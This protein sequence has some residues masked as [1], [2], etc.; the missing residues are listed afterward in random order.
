[1]AARILV[2]A[3]V[4]TATFLST[5]AAA[6]QTAA[7]AWRTAPGGADLTRPVFWEALP[8]ATADSGHVRIDGQADP[9]RPLV[10]QV[11]PRIDARGDF[12]LVASLQAATDS[13]AAIVLLDAAAEADPTPISPRIEVGLQHGQVVLQVFDGS[14]SR[15]SVSQSFATDAPLGPVTV[16]L[17]HSKATFTLEVSGQPVGEVDDPGIFTSDTA[18]LGARVA[19]D[20]QLTV[21]HLDVQVPAAD[22]AAAPRAV[23]RCAP[24]RLLVTGSPPANTEQTGLYW[25]YPDTDPDLVRPIELRQTQRSFLVALSPDR[26]W[27]TYYQRSPL[28]TRDRFIVDTWVLDLATDERFKLVD[29]NAPLAWIADSSAVVLGDRPYLMASVPSGE[30]LPTVGELIMPDAMRVAASPDGHYRAA[31]SN[32]PGG[33]AGINILDASSGELVMSVP[34]GRGAIEVAW[35][36]DSSRLAFTSGTDGVEGLVWKLRM[37]DLADRSITLF[38]STR[39]MEI[40]SVVWAPRL[41]GCA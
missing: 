26:R 23:T 4:A 40:H 32:A 18:L 11:G 3:L 29:G 27:V 15:P 5:G 25:L 20:N 17:A 10:D 36:P 16:G 30:L 34:T 39:D 2:T 1:M 12:R 37:V 28:A 35:A 31:V 7:V 33:A 8:W 13:V 6:A 22:P 24:S 21:D 38:E 9:A 14:S 19:T 41:A